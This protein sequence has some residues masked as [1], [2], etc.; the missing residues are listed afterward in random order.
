M[1]HQGDGTK[2][3]YQARRN[4]GH[5]CY[6]FV[7]AR[8]AP[9]SALI[10]TV[11]RQAGVVQT[12]LTGPDNLAVIQSLILRQ[13]EFALLPKSPLMLIAR[14]SPGKNIILP[15]LIPV[16]GVSQSWITCV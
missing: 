12:G 7:G 1:R 14:I 16:H 15:A 4:R 13:G 9:L 2:A 11:W 6:S 8:Q 3:H 5:R 10:G